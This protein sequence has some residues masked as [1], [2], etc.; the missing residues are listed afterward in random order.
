MHDDQYESSTDNFNAQV[1]VGYLF[2]IMR[3]PIGIIKK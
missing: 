3:A 1:S 2:P